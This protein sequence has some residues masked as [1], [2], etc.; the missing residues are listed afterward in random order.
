MADVDVIEL[1][2]GEKGPYADS[3]IDEKFLDEN[4]LPTDNFLDAIKAELEGYENR[5]RNELQRE[6]MRK[7]ETWKQEAKLMHAYKTQ[8]RKSDTKY[9]NKGERLIYC[10]LCLQPPP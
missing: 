7:A 5:R 10:T 9:F 4:G 2:N 1:L 8:Q 3:D 6:E